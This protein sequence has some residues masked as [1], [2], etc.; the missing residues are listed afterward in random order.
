MPNEEYPFISFRFHVQIFVP[1]AQQQGM[2]ETL[3]NMEFAEMDGL[4][5]SME[6]KVV[7]E[8]GNNLQQLNLIGRV[9]YG[10][11]TL[12][13][14]MTS[15]LDLWKW[16]NLT[17]RSGDSISRPREEGET[18]PENPRARG[19]VLVKDAAGKDRLRYN[20]EGCIP[21]KVKAPA[22]NAR[23]GGIAIEEMQIAVS[24]FTMEV[25]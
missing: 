17:A 10:N 22:F 4:E 13:R 9:N 14:G 21:I 5:M 11:I 25:A 1:G 18:A 20:L 16:F 19:V 23:E 8:G 12:K 2:G 15:N 3:C 24:S 6:P 7:R